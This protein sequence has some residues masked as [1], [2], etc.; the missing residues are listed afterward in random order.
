MWDYRRGT[1]PDL[2]GSVP[3]TDLD[4]LCVYG[5]DCLIASVKDW[6]D[7]IEAG[8]IPRAGP[9][10]LDLAPD[11]LNKADIGGGSPYSVF[12]PE[13][14]A[15][16]LFFGDDF[17]QRFTDYLRHSF[18]WGGFPGLSNSDLPFAAKDR[19]FKLTKGFLPF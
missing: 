17:S 10:T 4:P 11:A 18:R 16:P 1:A 6:K 15:D 12:L 5:D 13:H 8:E 7:T 9:F 3:L 2:F 14:H 19:M